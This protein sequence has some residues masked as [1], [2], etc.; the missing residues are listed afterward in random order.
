MGLASGKCACGRRLNEEQLSCEYCARPM[1][2]E[3][4]EPIP[5]DLYFEDEL[6]WGASDD[7]D[8]PEPA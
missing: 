2:W 4:R 6:G 3:Y 8:E 5:V 1:F 7:L